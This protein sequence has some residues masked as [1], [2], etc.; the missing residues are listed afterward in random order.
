MLE[1]F[2][3]PYPDEIYKV[4]LYSEEFTSL[5]PKTGQPDFARI[6]IEYTPWVSCIET[7]SFKLYLFAFRNYKGFM[8]R[9]TNKIFKDIVEVCN[10]GYIKIRAD[11]NVRGGIQLAVQ[12]EAYGPKKD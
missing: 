11:F 10:P 2:A 4:E 6:L 7:K 12:R 8:E 5:C 9:I 1:I 3:N